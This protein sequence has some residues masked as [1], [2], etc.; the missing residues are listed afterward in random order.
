[1]YDKCIAFLIQIEQVP[2]MF[3]LRML[4]CCRLLPRCPT[5]II[6]EGRGPV[7]PIFEIPFQ[8]VAEVTFFSRYQV[9][10]RTPAQNKHNKR[11]T[12]REPARCV[13][14]SSDNPLLAR[15]S[16]RLE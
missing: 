16:D 11:H 4:E 1:M 3:V 10:L 13:P 5:T 2:K 8:A 6:W 15:V 9:R 12:S 14:G 7:S